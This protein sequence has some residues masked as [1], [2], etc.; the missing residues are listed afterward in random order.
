MKYFEIAIMQTDTQNNMTDLFVKHVKGDNPRQALMERYNADLSASLRT[1]NR[2]LKAIKADT[3]TDSD[4]SS[5]MSD[6]LQLDTFLTGV[7]EITSGIIQLDF[8]D[9]YRDGHT[10]KQLPDIVQ[11]LKCVEDHENIIEF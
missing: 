5:R 6:G 8:T 4:F 2:L 1:Y 11:V 3:A 7:T 9:V 10:E